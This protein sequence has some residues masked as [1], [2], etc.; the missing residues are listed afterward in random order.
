MY[1]GSTDGYFLTLE[2]QER[3]FLR[4]FPP[5]TLAGNKPRLLDG[6]LLQINFATLTKTKTFLKPWFSSAVRCLSQ[7]LTELM[8]LK[9]RMKWEGFLEHLLLILSCEHRQKRR[10]K[11]SLHIFLIGQKWYIPDH[12]HQQSNYSS[13]KITEKQSLTNTQPSIAFPRIYGPKHL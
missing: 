12:L 3:L 9:S 6:A 8:N 13:Y 11:K 4:L 1:L 2:A 7:D 5:I 10:S